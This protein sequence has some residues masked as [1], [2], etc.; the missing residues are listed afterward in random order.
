MKREDKIEFIKNQQLPQILDLIFTNDMGYEA[1]VILDNGIIYRE[2]GMFLEF[3]NTDIDR[4]LTNP[5]L[6]FRPDQAVEWN[7]IDNT[8]LDYIFDLVNSKSQE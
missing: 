8:T 6:F 1:Y 4:M 2:P 5:S 3:S 7:L